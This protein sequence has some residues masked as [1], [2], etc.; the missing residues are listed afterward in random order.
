MILVPL[1]LAAATHFTP[2]SSSSVPQLDIRPS[3]HSASVLIPEIQSTEACLRDENEA[4]GEL[5][6]NW[7][8]YSAG[9]KSRCSAEVMVGGDPS[10]V[11]L[12]VCL[13]LDQNLLPERATG[14]PAQMI[15]PALED[16]TST[17]ITR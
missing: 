5:A 7:S 4:K 3:C 17:G 10:Y 11:E 9:A 16:P 12:L 8:K 13:D 14:D 6:Q 2:V 15:A 1:M